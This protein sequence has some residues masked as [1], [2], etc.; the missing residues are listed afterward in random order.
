MKIL[1]LDQ[2]IAEGAGA[3][4]SVKFEGFHFDF[5]TAAFTGE[6][7]TI[8]GSE[9]WKITMEICND[10][11][12]KWST[13]DYYNGITS[14]G[15]DN[16]FMYEDD[17]DLWV[18]GGT[19]VWWVKKDDFLEYISDHYEVQV[20]EKLNI[21]PITADRL[22]NNKAVV[23]K[24][25]GY[26]EY[27]QK[28]L[29]DECNDSIDL[30]FNYGGG[31][32]HQNLPNP[33]VLGGA[34]GNNKEYYFEYPFAEYTDNFANV[35]IYCVELHIDCE[36]IVEDINNFYKYASYAY[37][38]YET[39]YNEDD[40]M[41][42][43]QLSDEHILWDVNVEPENFNEEKYNRLCQEALERLKAKYNTE[44]FMLGRSG[45]HV[46]VEDTLDNRVEYDD[47]AADVKAEQ[48]ELIN[49]LNKR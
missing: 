20:N 31:Y 23:E 49:K 32:A 42:Y 3:G 19:S 45:R 26:S 10:L 36:R 44:F 24:I 39:Y 9:H 17:E 14:D 25:K 8:N 4:Y 11:I 33:I 2:F 15:D 34:V 18:H 38:D 43:L 37:G 13:N 29:N 5:N 46:C 12:D 48:K 41:N 21:Q 1:S 6:R 16:M 22:K 30:E 7:K 28:F 35:C 47:M 27:L 40:G